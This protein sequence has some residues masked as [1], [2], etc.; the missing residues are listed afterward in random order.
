MLFGPQGVNFH[1]A[2]EYVSLQSL[3]Q[4]LL[5]LEAYLKAFYTV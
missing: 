4:Y 1:T 2:Q 5:E 3:E